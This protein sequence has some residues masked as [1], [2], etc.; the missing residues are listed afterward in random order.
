M[1]AYPDFARRCRM[2]HDFA[3]QFQ[4]R[5]HHPNGEPYDTWV[6]GEEVLS[7]LRA[8]D[9]EERLRDLGQLQPDELGVAW[10]EG[11]RKAR[12]SLADRL[13]DQL[14]DGVESMVGGNPLGESLADSVRGHSEA[15]GEDWAGYLR[16][17][18]FRA[19]ALE[20]AWINLR[21]SFP[22]P[23]AADELDDWV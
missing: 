3:D 23:G 18:A 13:R 10:E 11:K 21:G 15:Q 6:S 12:R 2:R 17:K 8:A 5:Y 19:V 7:R 1:S 4:V 20:L 14:G 22:E 16:D 9:A